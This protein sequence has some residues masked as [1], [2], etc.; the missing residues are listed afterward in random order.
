M[1]LGRGLKAGRTFAP[2]TLGKWGRFKDIIGLGG[3]R[4]MHGWRSTTPTMKKGPEFFGR[5]KKGKAALRKLMK[6]D[7]QYLGKT[8]GHN[9]G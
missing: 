5:G 2:G 7:P 6:E 3:A 9:Y 4:G 1:K 8:S